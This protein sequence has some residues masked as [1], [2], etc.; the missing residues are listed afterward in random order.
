MADSDNN[1]DLLVLHGKRYLKQAR[2][3]R[4]KHINVRTTA[5]H[6][7]L[8]LPWLDWGGEIYIPEDEGDAYIASRVKRRNPRRQRR[9][10]IAATAEINA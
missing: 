10:A 7:Q 8:G 4:E 6:R 9:Q 3:S 5:R 2:W 1:S